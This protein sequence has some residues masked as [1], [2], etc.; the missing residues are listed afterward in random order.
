M[1]YCD[2]SPSAAQQYLFNLTKDIKVIEGKLEVIQSI[3]NVLYIH[4][5]EPLIEQ[6]Q[7]DYGFPFEYSKESIDQDLNNTITQARSLLV[8]KQV[9]EGEY[10]KYNEANKGKKV[11]EAD[12]EELLGALSQ[13]QTYE[14]DSK[15]LTVSRF[16]GIFNRYNKQNK[17][18]IK[19]ED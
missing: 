18:G 2:L 12:Y 3:V 6:L 17:H 4:Y 1:E 16:V 8:Q 15:V 10:A 11:S 5:S 9:K 19:S 7:L 14:L 13:F